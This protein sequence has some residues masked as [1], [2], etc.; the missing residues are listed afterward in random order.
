MNRPSHCRPESGRPPTD[1]TPGQWRHAA[2]RSTRGRAASA[3]RRFLFCIL[4]LLP[5]GMLQ[6]EPYIGLSSD[7]WNE[8]SPARGEIYSIPFTLKE[9]ARV[10]IAITGPDRQIVRTL[11]SQAVLEPGTHELVW[12]GRDD[13]GELVPDEA[14]VPVAKATGAAGGARIDPWA[15]SGGEI[16]EDLATRIGP[17]GA[18][19]YRL[20]VPARVLIRVGIEGGPMLATLADWVPHAAGRNIQHWNGFDADGVADL[21]GEP[22]LSL[23]VTAFALPDHA[24]LTFGNGATDYPGWQEARGFE[25]R[26]TAPDAMVLERDGRRISPHH[27]YGR[28]LDR[29]PRVRLALGGEEVS[30]DAPIPTV[31]GRTAIRVDV[32]EEDRWLLDESLYEV[33]F[34]IDHRFV[35]EEEQG[36]LPLSWLWDAATLDPGPHLLTVNVSGF[37]GQVGVKTVRFEVPAGKASTTNLSQGG[38]SDGEE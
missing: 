9:P 32:Q 21:R 33:A 25:P 15:Y 23:L 36:Y 37:R 7:G 22:G 27:Y 24:I 3:G 14:W 2:S 1:T 17:Q 38:E 34:F 30:G 26:T 4:L 20:P 8:F 31:S 29:D 28:T 12:D 18:I 10:E 16:L 11:D 5:F 13:N 6:A 35:S 19:S